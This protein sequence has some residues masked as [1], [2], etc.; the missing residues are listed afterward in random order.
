MDFPPSPECPKLE[1]YGDEE[2]TP[3]KPP[4]CIEIDDDSEDESLAS[5]TT[6]YISL[7]LPPISPQQEEEI[8]SIP[9]VAQVMKTIKTPPG[10]PPLTPQ[11]INLIYEAK[12]GEGK[13]V[14]IKKGD[15]LISKE[16]LRALTGGGDLSDAESG[17]FLRLL[18]ERAEAKSDELPTVHALTSVFVFSLKTKGYQKPRQRKVNIFDYR[19]ILCPVNV[20]RKHWTLAVIDNRRKTIFYYDSLSW[21]DSGHIELLKKY[22]AAEYEDIHGSPAPL[23]DVKIDAG[24]PQQVGDKDCGVFMCTFAE[25]HTRWAKFDFCQDHIPYLRNKMAWELLTDQMTT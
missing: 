20:Y 7:P 25:L 5:L 15:V 2:E 22:V 12:K 21:S 13:E 8:A 11:M 4:Q 3:S 14:I 6:P 10:F 17:G 18:E 19:Y 1:D 9:A 23:Y 16:N 24:V